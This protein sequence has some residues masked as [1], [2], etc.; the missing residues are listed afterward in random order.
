[1]RKVYPQIVRKDLSVMHMMVLEEI[2][3]RRKVTLEDRE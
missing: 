2:E 3:E 1:M